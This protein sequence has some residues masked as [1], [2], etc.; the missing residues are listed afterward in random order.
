M[1]REGEKVLLL[2]LGPLGNAV[3][4]VLQK[5]EAEG[6]RAAHYDVRFLKP[7]DEN[8][9]EKFATEY[10]AWITVEDGTEKGGLFSEIS[11]F[12]ARRDARP[13]LLH[14]ALPDRF[15][16]HGDIPHLYK[17]VGFDEEAIAEKV[18][19]AWGD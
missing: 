16:S 14:I 15:I 19:E 4:N 5:L 18:K 10:S 12:L 2:T 7:L 11:E 17:E 8:V 6:I 3:E 9:L 1:L 13:R